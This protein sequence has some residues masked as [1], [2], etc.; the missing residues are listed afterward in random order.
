MA[1]T[2]LPNRFEK[3][4]TTIEIDSGSSGAGGSKAAQYCVVFPQKIALGTGAIKLPTALSDSGVVSLGSRR[5]ASQ[6]PPPDG[7]VELDRGLFV[8]PRAMT[9]AI[10]EHLTG[11]DAGYMVFDTSNNAPKLWNGSIWLTVQA[12][13]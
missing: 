5:P 11:D 7:L 12:T 2:I 10:T 9:G 8:P 4:H 1:C 6:S 3:V 13:P